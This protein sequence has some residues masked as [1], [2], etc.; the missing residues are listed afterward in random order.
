ME[1]TQVIVC[2]Q[3]TLMMALVEFELV[4]SALPTEL[5]SQASFHEDFVITSLLTSVQNLPQ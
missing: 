4:T 2:L 5:R 3:L 1:G